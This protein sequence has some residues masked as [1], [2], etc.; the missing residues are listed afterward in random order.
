MQMYLEEDPAYARLQK[1]LIVKALAHVVR[2]IKGFSDPATDP[3]PAAD[4]AAFFAFGFSDV[5]VYTRG[6]AQSDAAEE[7]AEDAAVQRVRNYANS[8]NVTSV[9]NEGDERRH[10]VTVGSPDDSI[11]L[12]L[13]SKSEQLTIKAVSEA[14]ENA[15]RRLLVDILPYTGAPVAVEILMQED[16]S[17]EYAVGTAVAHIAGAKGPTEFA[18]M[19]AWIS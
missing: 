3:G 8:I 13:V 1:S 7:E 14:I 4:L 19:A 10:E 9:L 2:E 5:A 12:E 16:R 18:V 17:S 6:S 15:G 11:T